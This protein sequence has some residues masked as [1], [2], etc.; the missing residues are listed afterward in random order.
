MIYHIREIKLGGA[1][2][3]PTK[4]LAMALDEPIE[5]TMAR[6]VDLGITY[7]CQQYGLDTDHP[8]T[9]ELVDFVKKF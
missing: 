7:L 3:R 1:V 5:K 8:R 6:L 4:H 9:Y 2:Y